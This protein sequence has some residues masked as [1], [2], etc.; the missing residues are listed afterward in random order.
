LEGAV[1]LRQAD[2]GGDFGSVQ[3]GAPL[4]SGQSLVTRSASRVAL[5][6]RDGS[7]LR[8]DQDTRLHLT[9]VGEIELESG[10]IYLD[11]GEARSSLGAPVVL[12]PAGPVRHRGTRYM[13][14]VGAGVTRISVRDGTVALARPGGEELASGGQQL[15]VEST[16]AASLRAIPVYGAAWQ[17]AEAL[18]APYASDG[19]SLADFLAWV[20]RETGQGVEYASPEAAAVA[21]NSELRGDVAMEPTRA[22]DVVMQASDLVT[23]VNDGIISVRLRSSD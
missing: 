19:R 3:G 4:H 1:L 2:A 22:L 6:W 10:R 9:T 7:V 23:E 8:I 14:A 13:T 11:T 20:G 15:V 21:E 16:G 12:T 5:R 18:A 17:W